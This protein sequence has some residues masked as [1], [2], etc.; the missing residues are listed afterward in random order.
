MFAMGQQADEG[1]SPRLGRERGTIITVIALIGLSIVARV[2]IIAD[3][4][5]A[6]SMSM[7]SS[8]S[9][10]GDMSMGASGGAASASAALAFLIAWAVMMAAMLPSA[11]PM[12]GL[13]GV[14]HRRCVA[15]AP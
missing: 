3:A 4:M 14:I 7:D 2:A 1:G 9:P 8:S 10:M 5:R 15:S 13:Y 12:I 11:A 6:G